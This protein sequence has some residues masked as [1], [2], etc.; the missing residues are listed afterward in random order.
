[1]QRKTAPAPTLQSE[2]TSFPCLRSN[3]ILN[4]RQGI[5]GSVGADSFT[6]KPLLICS[7]S[8]Y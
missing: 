5:A 2:K 6:I 8:K 7:V 3:Q 1:M 4:I